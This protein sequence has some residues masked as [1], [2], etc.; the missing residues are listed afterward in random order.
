MHYRHYDTNAST[1]FYI[2]ALHKK[3]HRPTNSDENTVFK[4]EILLKPV[5][6]CSPMLKFRAASRPKPIMNG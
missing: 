6:P 1:P 3:T 2:I 4:V 5:P